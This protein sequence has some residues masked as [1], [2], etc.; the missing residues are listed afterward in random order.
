MK[1]DEV[2]LLLRHLY[3]YNSFCFLKQATPIR[4]LVGL[5]IVTISCSFK[6]TG[7]LTQTKGI[8]LDETEAPPLKVWMRGLIEQSKHFT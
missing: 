6:N 1:F 7:H 5:N 4:L 2:G 3:E 8:S